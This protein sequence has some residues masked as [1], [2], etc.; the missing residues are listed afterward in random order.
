MQISTI[1]RQSRLPFLLALLFSLQSACML[2]QTSYTW[3]AAATSS[4][5]ATAA[6]WTPAGVPGATDHVTIVSSSNPPVLAANTSVNNFTISSGSIN[7]GGNTLAIAGNGSF[8]GASSVSNGTVQ[9]TGTNLTFNGCTF[10]ANCTVNS[11]TANVIFNSGTFNG[12]TTIVKNGTTDNNANGN[13]TFNGIT[14]IRINAAGRIRL[15]SNVVFNGATT[16]IIN[17]GTDYMLFDY[18]KPAQFN[19]DLII[20][21]SGNTAGDIRLAYSGN[22]IFN[23][24]IYVNSDGTGD[25]L[26][27]ELPTASA[28]L[29]A[30]KKILNGTIGFNNGNLRLQRF[31]Q[32][33]TT[34]QILSL[35]GNSSTITFGPSSVF[36]AK[37]NFS[38]A[39]IMLSGCDFNNDTTELT[40]IGTSSNTGLGGNTF[41]GVS[42]FRKAST[43]NTS[44]FRTNGGNTYTGKAHFINLAAGDILFEL[45]TGST[46]NG[47]VYASNEGT[48][49]VRLGYA[50]TNTFNNNIE[51]KSTSGTGI[52]FGE[53]AGASL[54]LASG[55]T[56]STSSFS[57]GTLNINRFTQTGSTAHSFTLTGSS[58]LTIA[59]SSTFNGKFS[60]SVPNLYLSASTF[61]DSAYF[62]KTSATANIMAGGCTFQGV[63]S[64]IKPSGSAYIRNN[65]GNTFNDK[66]FITNQAANEFAFDYTTGSTYGGAVSVINSTTGITRLAYIGTNT[67]NGDVVL[68]NTSSGGIYFGESASTSIAF[69]GNIA[70]NNTSSG[71]LSFCAGASS[72]ATLASGKTIAPG[73]SGVTGGSVLLPRFT[74]LGSTPQSITFSGT[75]TNLTIGPAS[76]F[77]GKSTFIAPGI[78][79]SGVTFQDTAYIEKRGTAA[80]AGAGNNIFNSYVTLSKTSGAGT[81]GTWRVNGNNTFNGKVLFQ[82]AS[83][84]EIAMEYVSG[85]TYNDDVT[86]VNTS[87]GTTRMGYLGTTTFNGDVTVR[88]SS[89]G[90]ALFGEGANAAVVLNGNVVLNNTSTGSVSFSPGATA[91]TRLATG[92]TITIGSSGF[93]G[94]NILMPRFT[95]LGATAQTLAP[96]GTTNITTGPAS[97]WGGK[98]TFTAP[99]LTLSGSVFNDS[100]I[101]QKTGSTDN[102]GLGGNNFKSFAY[103]SN[104]GAGALFTGNANADTFAR[105]L[106]ISNSGT[107]YVSLAH[108]HTAKTSYFADSVIVN[109]S[110]ASGTNPGVRFG[111]FNSSAAI[112]DGV[113]TVNNS[114]TGSNFVRFQN[115]T[116]TFTFNGK[117]YLNNTATGAAS[118]IRMNSSGPGIYNQDI[119]VSST[120]GTGVIFGFSTG[121]ATLNSG[122]LVKI[123]TAGFSAGTLQLSRITQTG[124][125]AHSYTL[126]GTALLAVSNSSFQAP[127]SF[128]A[129][130]I[131]IASNTFNGSVRIEKTGAT[132]NTSTGGNTFNDTTNIINSSANA[133]RLANT[134]ADDYNSLV[135]FT[136]TGT[137]VLDPANNAASTFANHIIFAGN[138]VITTGSGGTSGAMVFDGNIAQSI[139]GNSTYAPV[140]TRL[141]MSSTAEGSLTLQVP[142][143]IPASGRL[144]L[145]SGILNTSAT[146]L[147]TAG[148]A[149]TVDLGSSTSFINGPFHYQMAAAATRTLN[150]PVGKDGRYRPFELTVVHNAATAYTYASEMIHESAKA[151]GKTLPATITAVSDINYWRINRLLTSTMVASSANLSGNQTIKFYYSDGDAVTDADDLRIVKN[152]TAAPN[153]WIDIGGVGTGVENGTIT[154][155]SDPS[156]FNS[157]SDFALGNH[158]GGGNAL[159]V[160]LISMEAAAVKSA[161]DVEWVTATEIDNKGFEV[162]R[163]IDGKSFEKIGWVD[164]NGSTTEKIAYKFQDKEVKPNVI[165]YYRLNQIDFDGKNERS[166]IASAVIK[167]EEAG[168]AAEGGISW[169][170]FIPN[171]ASST[172]HLVINSTL[173]GAADISIFD[174]NGTQ[175]HSSKSNVFHGVNDLSMDLNE[176]SSGNYMAVIRFSGQV[177]NV[178]LMLAK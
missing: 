7:L 53:L 98:V 156:A 143:S 128:T 43:S 161:I 31:T 162:E 118:V 139:Q 85:S 124:S 56:L 125:S 113:V 136:Q 103:I 14:Q 61:G 71:T 137:G 72:S 117:V 12:P 74:Q 106:V 39:N 26:F 155:T 167:N 35:A 93:S 92:K 77:N 110:S 111:E 173:E 64:F 105:K 4:T 119:E 163:S 24:D 150:F 25:I 145:T 159:P 165:Y 157:F 6:N 95:Q 102:T 123:G 1:K 133:L 86:I 68:S 146:N 89:T 153:S 29:A 27:C 120:A 9:P 28:T 34:P 36:N 166:P 174:M 140:I 75:T 22:T 149:A 49:T 116:G 171:P 88:L 58:T 142:V 130:Q 99:Q 176:L 66:L 18:L 168:K 54:T 96:T 144:T 60:A 52:T 127:V 84:S 8:T 67:F 97:S 16:T 115:G 158:I 44:V 51:V 10:A 94:G 73:V 109:V 135:T 114:G 81:T 101:L 100:A 132:D 175:V 47:E 13:I 48:G 76:T 169:S 108:A 41:A 33:G 131:T 177:V 50:G 30:G 3:R 78:T 129:P 134:T 46:F 62:R 152:T 80:T 32:L 164:G 170:R 147:I 122:K 45:L 65:G 21:L 2:A 87:T 121:T 151:L 11:S 38:A 126:T 20:Y 148:N 37:V 40:K 70:L 57:A 42:I 19:G 82:N 59:N 83:A 160:K 141:S 112:F 154:S 63:T 138:R 55:K 178:K 5:W 107:G 79:L 104:S 15:D 91:A 17:D 90:S 172:A 23:G 69:N